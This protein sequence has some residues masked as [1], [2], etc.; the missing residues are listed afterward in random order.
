LEIHASGRL[1]QLLGEREA[2]L[3]IYFDRPP[4]WL[5][6]LASQDLEAL[7][8]MGT[9][10]L[11]PLPGHQEL[12]GLVS[13]GVKLSELPYSE[14]DKRLLRAV[15]AQMGLALENSRFSAMLAAEAAQ[16]ERIRRELEIA[17]EEGGGPVV[18][19][20]PETCYEQQACNLMPGD[21]LIAY[22]DGLSEAMNERGEE[23][24]EDRLFAAAQACVARSA[25]EM[26]EQAVRAADAFVG[27]AD[28]HDD[29]TLLIMKIG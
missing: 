9:Q 23:F 7:Q 8:L 1:A 11:L 5:P 16:R 14:T 17:R 25:R 3:E 15:A 26:I 29:M 18:G 4:E 19:L 13:L 2:P 27:A 24:G 20:F 28:Q 10:L 21:I 6:S 12:V 22:T